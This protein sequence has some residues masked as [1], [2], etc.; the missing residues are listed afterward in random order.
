LSHR[1]RA[2]LLLYESS[3]G[4]PSNKNLSGLPKKGDVTVGEGKLSGM[5][6][7]FHRYDR[8][9]SLSTRTGFPVKGEKKT[10]RKHILDEGEKGL[11][12]HVWEEASTG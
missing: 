2:G 8:G 4:I 10:E 11:G 5:R 12:A 1:N 6:P 3:S 7:R 9:G